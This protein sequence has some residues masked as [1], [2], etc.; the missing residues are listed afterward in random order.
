MCDTLFSC[1]CNVTKQTNKQ[2]KTLPPVNVL[3]VPCFT[4][5]HATLVTSLNFPRLSSLCTVDKPLLGQ[6]RRRRERRGT[7]SVFCCNVTRP[8]F[9]GRLSFVAAAAVRVCAIVPESVRV[10][11]DSIAQSYSDDSRPADTCL[12][13]CL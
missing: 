1:V 5:R 2:T 11:F 10:R 7:S 13:N 8:W 12:A 3:D 9:A 6:H 4:S